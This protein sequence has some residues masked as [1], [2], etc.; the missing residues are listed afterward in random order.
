MRISEL[1]ELLGLSCDTIRFYEKRGLLNEQHFIRQSNGYRD[2]SET[3]ISRLQLIKQGQAAGLTLTEI[4]Q[5]IDAWESNQLSQGEKVEFFLH[6]LE[7]I[8][9]RIAQLEAIKAYLHEKLDMMAGRCQDADRES[10]ETDT[11][12]LLTA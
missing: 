3:A 7:E 4:G 8:D 1:A 5:S 2:Y 12:A 9:T 10:A 11:T 6:K